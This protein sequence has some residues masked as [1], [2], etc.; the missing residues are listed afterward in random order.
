MPVMSSFRLREELLT[1]I[2][3]NHFGEKHSTVTD[4]E[5]MRLKRIEGKNW[6]FMVNDRTGQI[7]YRRR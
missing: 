7:A 3:M 2:Q 6:N 4:Y 1:T 5:P